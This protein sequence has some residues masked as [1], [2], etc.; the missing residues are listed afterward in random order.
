MTKCKILAAILAAVIA[1]SSAALLSGCGGQDCWH[2]VVQDTA[3][4]YYDC[5][6]SSIFCEICRS[7]E[8][9]PDDDNSSKNSV[10][11]TE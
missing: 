6:V 8:E 11:E 4:R 7:S 5:F 10:D 9:D 2:V 1:L 3:G